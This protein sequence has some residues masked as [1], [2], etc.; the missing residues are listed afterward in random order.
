LLV[1]IRDS[2][3]LADA[4]RTVFENPDRAAEWGRAARA[5]ASQLNP[6]MYASRLKAEMQKLIYISHNQ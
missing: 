2:P 5:T 4:I 1:P 6:E 3:A